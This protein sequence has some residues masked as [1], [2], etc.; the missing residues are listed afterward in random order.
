[1]QQTKNI[2]YENLFIKPLP[3]HYFT[4]N[5]QIRKQLEISPTKKDIQSNFIKEL[6]TSVKESL[7]LYYPLTNNELEIVNYEVGYSKL[8]LFLTGAP[9]ILGL[10]GLF[11]VN[12]KSGTKLAD[13]FKK[14]AFVINLSCLANAVLFNKLSTPK[15]KERDDVITGAAILSS[16][17]NDAGKSKQGI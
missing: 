11:V 7:K 8:G 1:M 16:I 13:L 17:V 2:N 14:N 9:M 3:P 5:Y 6:K 10:L 15:V 4:Y 12:Y